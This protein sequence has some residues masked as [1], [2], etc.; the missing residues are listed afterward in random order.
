MRIDG[1]TQI[2][3]EQLDYANRAKNTVANKSDKSAVNANPVSSNATV[4][5][6]VELSGLHLESNATVS[7]DATDKHS[8][9][10][11]NL[12]DLPDVR[13]D[14]VAELK[15]RIAAGEYNVSGKDIAEKIV[16]TAVENLF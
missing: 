15:A 11:N 12:K 7:K 9:M 4:N 16:N 1:K 2:G 14:K 6:A 10:V 5:D 8:T 3:M 13:K